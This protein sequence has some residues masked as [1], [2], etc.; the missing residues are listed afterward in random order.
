MQLRCGVPHLAIRSRRTTNLGIDVACCMKPR[1]FLAHRQGFAWSP[2]RLVVH[3]VAQVSPRTGQA[4]PKVVGVDL[5]HLS[6]NGVAYS[7]IAPR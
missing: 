2:V 1:V 3:K 5:Q 7:K 6:S 4:L